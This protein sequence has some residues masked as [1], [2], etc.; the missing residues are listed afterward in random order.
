MGF[1]VG[2]LINYMNMDG[3]LTTRDENM[4]LGFYNKDKGIRKSK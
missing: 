1:V 4:D 2:L 3:L